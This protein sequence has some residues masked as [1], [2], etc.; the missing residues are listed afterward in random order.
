MQLF[1]FVMT[2][3]ESY[4]FISHTVRMYALQEGISLVKS[5]PTAKGHLLTIMDELETVSVSSV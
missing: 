1:S 4:C 2:F 5:D 3:I